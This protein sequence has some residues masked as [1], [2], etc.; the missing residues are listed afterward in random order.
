MA[1]I[2]KC[3]LRGVSGAE[4]PLPIS[5]AYRRFTSEDEAFAAIEAL[6][7]GGCRIEPS[8]ATPEK[9]RAR[10]FDVIVGEG[11]EAFTIPIELDVP[12]VI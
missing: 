7:V 12:L 1:A 3:V 8:P 5:L 11:D 10:R 2:G 9:P 6:F 4:H